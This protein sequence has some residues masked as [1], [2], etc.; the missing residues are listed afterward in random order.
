[1]RQPLTRAHATADDTLVPTPRR[2]LSLRRAPAPPAAL[3]HERIELA[4]RLAGPRVLLVED[5]GLSAAITHDVLTGAGYRVTH[6]DDGVA[7]LEA[8]EHAEFDLVITDRVMPRMDGL[9]LCRALRARTA[10]T[11]IYVLML[12]AL[13]RKSD[14][15]EG[16]AS[17][18]DDYLAKPFDA[19]EL[20]AR[21]RAGLRIVGLQQELA[22]ANQALARM[23]L[24]DPL[25]ELS[26]RR[27]IDEMLA[28]DAMQLERTGVPTVVA[29]VDLDHFKAIN[30]AHGHA[31]G[32]LV[33]LAVAR[34]LRRNS[35][36]ADTCGRI[37]GEEF[38]LLLRGCDVSEAATLCERIRSEIAALSIPVDD[39]TVTLTASF[40]LA[41]LAVEVRPADALYRA[42]RG[43]HADELW[44][45]SAADAL[46][47]A[48]DALYRAK[49][50]GRDRVERAA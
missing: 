16:L 34:V 23:A 10:T 8:V 30:D 26:N 35:R 46:R 47:A 24:T 31:A 40:G 2:P 9:D 44:Q 25:T 42:R 17:G 5:S 48:D 50:L 19:S 33:L 4:I 39:A 6:V 1:V 12:T 29:V 3:T 36:L 21:V 15:V 43:T 41:S 18:A 7:A 27:A 37:G 20:L 32:D 49:S 38:V 22:A 11:G 28:L 45:R 13:D 14:I